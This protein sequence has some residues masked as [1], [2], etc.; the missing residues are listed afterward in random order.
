MNVVRERYQTLTGQN[1]TRRGGSNFDL[2]SANTLGAD[3][4]RYFWQKIEMAV[5]GVATL[6]KPQRRRADGR[7]ASGGPITVSE[8]LRAGTV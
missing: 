1:Q 8:R 7:R 4:E 2:P 6:A 3:Q 5:W